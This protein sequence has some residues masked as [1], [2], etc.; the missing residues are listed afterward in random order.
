MAPLGDRFD[1]DHVVIVFADQW[2]AVASPTAPETQAE[3]TPVAA[4][5]RLMKPLQRP[6]PAVHCGVLVQAALHLS[7]QWHGPIEEVMATCAGSARVS[8]SGTGGAT[9]LLDLEFTIVGQDGLVDVQE[10]W[11]RELQ[12]LYPFDVF[13]SGR[14]VNAACALAVSGS[15]TH[16]WLDSLKFS[17]L[18]DAAVA[19]GCFEQVGD[20]FQADLGLIP[21]GRKGSVDITVAAIQRA[22]RAG[23]VL[24]AGVNHREGTAN[25]AINLRPVCRSPQ[26]QGPDFVEGEQGEGACV[27]VGKR[28]APA[29]CEDPDQGYHWTTLEAPT[30][31]R[32]GTLADHIREDG[33]TRSMY[34]QLHYVLIDALSRGARDSSMGSFTIKPPAVTRGAPQPTSSRCA[35]FVVGSVMRCV[36]PS[37]P[38]PLKDSLRE[39]AV[40]HILAGIW[41]LIFRR[42]MESAG[43]EF[44]S[45]SGGRHDIEAT[46]LRDGRWGTLA[47]EAGRA[48]ALVKTADACFKPDGCFHTQNVE[49][50][51]WCWQPPHALKQIRLHAVFTGVLPMGE[52]MKRTPGGI[53]DV[54]RALLVSQRSMELCSHQDCTAGIEATEQAVRASGTPGLLRAVAAVDFD[55]HQQIGIV[56]GSVSATRSRAGWS[57]PCKGP[58]GEEYFVHASEGWAGKVHPRGNHQHCTIY[59][60]PRPKIP[61]DR[62]PWSS[63]VNTRL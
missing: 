36:N 58:D 13:T 39:N 46:G 53:T 49:R 42:M 41:Q 50:G 27:A 22:A 61:Y 4:Q 8:H 63:T 59:H 2:D 17:R 10:V 30:D 21:E 1:A 19:S 26:D 54:E 31:G 24:L 25:S 55:A 14:V 11:G 56:Q 15:L 32:P 3:S 5:T 9:P 7:H 23:R 28:K 51:E 35:W 33:G 52:V 38:P 12:Q 20:S 18:V 48:T 47:S 6:T 34:A 37:I 57:I 62:T 40:M 43:G 60:A 45:A 16:E 44:A 29:A